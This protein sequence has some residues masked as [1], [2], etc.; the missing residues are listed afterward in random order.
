MVVLFM[1]V[2]VDFIGLL[3][4]ALRFFKYEFPAQ[5]EFWFRSELSFSLRILACVRLIWATSAFY[6]IVY[7]RKLLCYSITSGGALFLFSPLFLFKST[8]HGRCG[9][10]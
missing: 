3:W 10:Q 5:C 6:L 4:C 2:H 8:I 9:A 7:E 1:L